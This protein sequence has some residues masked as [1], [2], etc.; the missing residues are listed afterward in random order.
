MRLYKQF[1]IILNNA[2]H[3]ARRI[4][5]NLSEFCRSVAVKNELCRAKFIQAFSPAM[6]SVSL[7]SF[8]LEYAVN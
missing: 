5:F 7:W 3:Q 4:K 6:I 8:K 2:M 1:H